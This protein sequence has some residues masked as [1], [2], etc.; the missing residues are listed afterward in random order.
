V[1]GIIASVN[2][3]FSGLL[4]GWHAAIISN[5]ANSAG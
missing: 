4:Y 2:E 3:A 5:A 1:S